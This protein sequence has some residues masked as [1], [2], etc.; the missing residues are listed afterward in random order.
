MSIKKV[1]NEALANVINNVSKLDYVMEISAKRSHTPYNKLKR[2]LI[3]DDMSTVIEYG[4]K[5]IKGAKAVYDYLDNFSFD[6]VGKTYSDFCSFEL[7]ISQ[8]KRAAWNTLSQVINLCSVDLQYTGLRL[9]MEPMLYGKSERLSTGAVLSDAFVYT[10]SFAD[11]VCSFNVRMAENKSCVTFIIQPQM[12]GYPI[13]NNDLYYFALLIKA[14][15]NEV[16]DLDCMVWEKEDGIVNLVA[17]HNVSENVFDKLEYMLNNQTQL[18]KILSV[19]KENQG[20]AEH[21]LVAF[22]EEALTDAEI[23]ELVGY[24]LDVLN[25]DILSRTVGKLEFLVSV[26]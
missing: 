11:D 21:V 22:Y 25:V 9:K 12:V 14:L 17:Y 7:A 2:S 18:P 8:E 24:K 26:K 4:N 16:L 3:V 5:T 13:S 10:V 23:V 19:S 1:T 15:T 6:F 20:L